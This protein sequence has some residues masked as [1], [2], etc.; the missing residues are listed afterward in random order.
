[1]TT[2]FCSKKLEKFLGIIESEPLP[3]YTNRLGNWNGHLFAFNR[4]KNLIFMNDRT[5][6]C[7]VLLNIKKSDVKAFANLF[8]ESLVN[9]LFNDLRISERQEIEVRKWVSE[10]QLARTNN[11][12]KILGTMNDFIQ[13]IKAIA[14]QQG[15]LHYLTN[16]SVGDG[17]NNYLIGT[18]FEGAKKSYSVPKE[19]MQDLLDELLS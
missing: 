13:N 14:D 5:A 8:R 2:V 17:L 7:F 11:N 9:Q 3:D 16:L 1:M 15:G 12:R 19:L 6:Y 18:R 4:K 10:I